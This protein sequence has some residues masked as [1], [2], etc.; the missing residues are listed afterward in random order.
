MSERLDALRGMLDDDPDDAFTRYAY[1]MELRSLE[2]T[3]EA[4]VEFEGLVATSGD[5]LATYYQFAR[6]LQARGRTAE[7]VEAARR[8]VAVATAQGDG[9]TQAELE[10]LLGELEG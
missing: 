2:R 5:Y 7:A 6:A 8:G 9:H 4:L 3:D 10:D 1:A